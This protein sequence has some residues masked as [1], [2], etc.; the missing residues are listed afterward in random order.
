[1][2]PYMADCQRRSMTYELNITVPL[3]IQ[4]LKLMCSSNSVVFKQLIPKEHTRF[5][6]KT[7]RYI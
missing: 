5:G 6:I 3:N 4:H 2:N 7:V 1:M